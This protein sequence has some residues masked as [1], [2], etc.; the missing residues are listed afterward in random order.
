[1]ARA[2]SVLCSWGPRTRSLSL[3][4]LSLFLSF[5]LSLFLSFSLSLF[6]SFSLSLFLSLSI[7]LSLFLSLVLSLFLSFS[8]S[9]SLSLSLSYSFFFSLSLS[10]VDI[11]S[12]QS[13]GHVKSAW[14]DNRRGQGL[15]HHK[16]RD[17]ELQYNRRAEKTKTSRWNPVTLT[18]EFKTKSATRG[19][20]CKF[21]SFP[22]ALVLR[23]RS[24]THC[25]WVSTTLQPRTPV[26]PL[27]TRFPA[28][29][30]EPLRVSSTK[31]RIAPYALFL[32][33]PSQISAHQHLIHKIAT[34]K[35]SKMP[36]E[37]VFGTKV[38]LN[39]ADSEKPWPNRDLCGEASSRK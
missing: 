18:R 36:R 23:N 19:E 22:L 11:R 24:P 16:T 14:P 28:P 39:C 10:D 30:V 13:R 17:C 5:S 25:P 34:L 12:P 38:Q 15:S 29:R 35:T 32:T 2:L 21:A 27:Q 4:S 37:T 3:F 8:L 20:K 7:S 31:L 33:P 9:F 1:M 26:R 6:L